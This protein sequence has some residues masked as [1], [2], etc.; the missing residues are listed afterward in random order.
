MLASTT[1]LKKFFLFFHRSSSFSGTTKTQ[2]AIKEAEMENEECGESSFS[3]RRPG[4]FRLF[5]SRSWSLRR[6]KS[7]ET[8][9]PQMTGL[10]HTGPRLSPS[11]SVKSQDSGFSDSGEGGAQNKV[12]AASLQRTQFF[13]GTEFEDESDPNLTQ[14]PDFCVPNPVSSSKAI[15]T[16]TA[17]QQVAESL[18][19]IA[20]VNEGL[21]I[22]RSFLDEVS[23]KQVFKFCSNFVFL[24]SLNNDI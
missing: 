15:S 17:K 2:E 23:K 18:G 24:I 7:L 3:A 1:N 13:S 14:V 11:Y 8:S 22:K 19:N 9:P 6:K 10:E 16:L 5:R 12:T 4:S 20:S 21:R